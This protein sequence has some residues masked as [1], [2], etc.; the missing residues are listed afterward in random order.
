MVG[1]VL[2]CSVVIK[3]VY[4]AMVIISIKYGASGQ[5]EKGYYTRSDN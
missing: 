3:A 2:L 4:G 5:S 1:L